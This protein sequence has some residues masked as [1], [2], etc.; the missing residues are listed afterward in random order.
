MTFSTPENAS[1]PSNESSLA[2]ILKK[3]INNMNESRNDIISYILL[4]DLGIS[5]IVLHLVNFIIIIIRKV[6]LFFAE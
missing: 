6:D 1:S 3:F 4:F 2:N 5:Q